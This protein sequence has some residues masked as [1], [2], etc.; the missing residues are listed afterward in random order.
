[1]RRFF[2]WLF[3]RRYKGLDPHD[4]RALTISLIT[5]EALR[6]LDKDIDPEEET[7]AM[8]K[9]ELIVAMEVF[10]ADSG[11]S[12]YIDVSHSDVDNLLLKYISDKDVTAAYVKVKDIV[13]PELACVWR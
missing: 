8:T 5:R 1:M 11:N 10:Y 7:K 6:K 2:R 13:Q 3:F 12:N 9:G 4:P